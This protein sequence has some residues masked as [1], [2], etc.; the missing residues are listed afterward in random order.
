MEPGEYARIAQVEERHWWYRGM[1]A[2]A[3]GWLRRWVWPSV[4]NLAQSRR[5]R[6]LDAGCGTGGGLRW[7]A[8]HGQVTGVDFHPLAV[9]YAAR[10]GQ[11]VARASVQ[12]LPFGAGSFDAVTCLDVLYHAAVTDDGQA[13]RE[14]ARVLVPGGWLLVRVPAYDWLRGAHDRQVHT[15]ERYT[16]GGLGR[17]LAAAG[18]EV[19][20][21]SYAGLCLL[22]PALLRRLTQGGGG[23]HSDVTLPHPALNRLLEGLLVAEGGWL[24]HAPLPAGLSVLALAQRPA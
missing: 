17:K 7:L 3:G 6:V 23:A 19:R 15:R 16:R 20:R 24:R 12:A 14:L 22:P 13:L 2:I 21:L 18:L 1:R 9:G 5:P 10:T 11:A 8:A 4:S